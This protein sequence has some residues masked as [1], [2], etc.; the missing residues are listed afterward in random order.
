MK[1]AM[2]Q[3]IV[4]PV[5]VH[6]EIGRHVVGKPH[7]PENPDKECSVNLTLRLVAVTSQHPLD[8]GFTDRKTGVWWA[9]NKSLDDDIKP[10]NDVIVQFHYIENCRSVLAEVPF[11]WG[12]TEDPC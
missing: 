5:E 1:R 8:K 3:W 12:I 4:S 9:H 11:V 7:H 6:Q 10:V 2:F